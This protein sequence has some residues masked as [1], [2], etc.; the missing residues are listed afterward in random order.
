MISQ[1]IES[2]NGLKSRQKDYRIVRKLLVTSLA[3][4]LVVGSSYLG[5]VRGEKHEMGQ[6]QIEANHRLDLFA[7]TVVGLIR[8][9]E[10]VPPTIQLNPQILALLR[11][12]SNPSRVVAASAY[13]RR[14][15]AH[16]GSMAVFTLNDRGVVVASSNDEF[17]DDSRMGTDVSF[18]PYF[19]EALSGRVGR[20]FAIGIDGKSPGYFVSHP[21]RDGAHVVGVAAIKIS[22]Q[23][24]EETWEMVDA[25]ALLV[26][27][28]RVV[29]DSSKPDWRYTS[30]ILQ[31]AEQRVDQQL[32]RLYDNLQ[33][34]LFPLGPILAPQRERQLVSGQMVL[35]RPLDGMDWRVMLFLDLGDVRHAALARA[36][37][38]GVAAAFFVLLCLVMVQAQRIQRQ[39]YEARR[40]LETANADL[41]SKVHVRTIDLRVANENLTH[42]VR[43]RELA[44]QSLRAAQSEL[45][46]TAKMAVLGQLATGI[47]HELTQPLGA[48]RTLSGNAEEFLRRGQMDPLAGNLKIISRLADQM[49]KII[50]PLK[51]FARKSDAKLCSIDIGKTFKN[52]LF[53]FGSRLR[54]MGVVVLNDT[55]TGSAYAWCDAN[56]LEQVLIN[57]I[58]NALDAMA[59]TPKPCLMLRAE[60]TNRRGEKKLW[61]RIEVEDN[62]SGLSPQA[63]EQLFEPF[64]TTKDQ[65]AGLGLGLVISR[66]IVHGFNGEI[67]VADRIGGGTCFVLM[68]PA[69][70][71][72]S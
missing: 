19:L 27:A 53:L 30:L 50:D 57:L 46:Q 31:T 55:P 52:A 7:S 72:I 59:A 49:G 25:P 40:M 18:R 20:H 13:L 39:R 61:M 51:A 70:G 12:P 63:R 2:V 71:P 5:Y 68:I 47:T 67:S 36:G 14:L 3:I 54:K 24:V 64:F 4:V 6:L 56:R 33:V 58:G 66:D 21:I 45:V 16:V 69:E 48:I 22:L 32:T 8:R 10:H 44:E 34:P 60:Q 62:G 15:N 23:A 17:P 38:S 42:E 11:D 1:W 43:E 9:L 37:T 35:T 28:N 41:E 29:I 65:G 26:D